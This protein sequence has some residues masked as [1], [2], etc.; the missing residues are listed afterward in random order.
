MLKLSGIIS[1]VLINEY[2]TSEFLKRLSDPLWFQAFGCV[3][4]FDWHS[5]GVTTVV[6]GVLKQS[7]SPESHGIVIAGGKGNQARK[8]QTEITSKC[9]NEFNHSENQLNNLLYASKMSAKVDNSAIQDNYFLYHHNIA[10]DSDGNWS[11]IQQGMNKDNKT[12]RRYQWFSKNVRKGSYVTEPHSGI[13]GDVIYGNNVLDMTS[14]DSTESQKV[15]VDILRDNLNCR[16]LFSSVNQLL[17]K[18]KDST[19]DQWFERSTSNPKLLRFD[20]AKLSNEYNAHY[21]MPKHVDWA[22]IRKLYD[23]PPSNYEEFL[24]IKGVGPSTVR[25]LTLIAELI[26]GTKSSWKD[27]AKY[28]FAHGGKDGVP[29]FVDRKSYD[30]SIKFLQSSIEGADIS[31]IEGISALKKLSN[32]NSNIYSIMAERGENL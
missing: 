12:A 13:I 30:D 26:F 6:M 17:S 2:G 8:T 4:G 14:I 29:Y 32:Y 3:L 9:N 15:V 25:A 7:L 24:S 20:L 1:K 11:I 28:S 10:F 31:R 21:S 23:G 5:S 27:P 19:I 18:R 22:R 16:D